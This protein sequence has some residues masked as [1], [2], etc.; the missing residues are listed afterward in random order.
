[1]RGNRRATALV[2]A[3]IGSTCAVPS[4]AIDLTTSGFFQQRF[5]IENNTEDSGLE[6]S[7][8]TDLGVIFNIQTPRSNFSIAPGVRLN[9]D[10]EIEDRDI[11]SF[12]LNAN[13]SHS[14]PRLGL[15][16]GFSV[17]PDFAR[18]S[19]VGDAV[20]IASDDVDPPD[21][22]PG[23]DPDPGTGDTADIFEESDVLELSI[24]GNV[25]A[26]YAIDPLTSV[27][28]TGFANA[29]QAVEDVGGTPDTSRYGVNLGLSRRLSQTTSVS[30]TPG[31]TY[32]TSRDD[33][34]TTAYRFT[35]GGSTQLR[36]DLSVNARLGAN[37]ISGEDGDT[38]TSAIF[39]G[40]IS[41]TGPPLASP[42]YRIGLQISQD[43][44]Q[45]DDGDIVNRTVL[46]LNGSYALND[47]QQFGA[48]AGIGLDT[49]VFGDAEDL[50]RLFAGVNYSHTL[51]RDWVARVGYSARID[52]DDEELS[53]FFFFQISRGF[54]LAR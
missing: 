32:F 20:V 44:N 3:I 30:V 6:P 13:A 2:A 27:S 28:L 38:E 54:I 4:M 24:S 43:T 12:R 9:W 34:D 48:N 52:D 41:Y 33:E 8:A 21:E 14:R 19:R 53:N 35:V 25:G 1:M 18:R 16:A 17:V 37:F 29:R 22:D 36:S 11:V 51:S 10:E 7:S 50:R 47:R 39:G 45:D 5:G 26:N 46:S 40:G 49:P 31:V 23:P 42:D 15:S